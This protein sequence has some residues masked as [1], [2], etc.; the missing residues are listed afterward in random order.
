MKKKITSR[1]RT[2]TCIWVS[3]KRSSFRNLNS[4]HRHCI[5]SLSWVLKPETKTW[6]VWPSK[7]SIWTGSFTRITLRSFWIFCRIRRMKRCWRKSLLRSLLPLCGSIIRLLSSSKYSSLTWYTY[8]CSPFSQEQLLDHTVKC[9]MTMEKTK[10]SKM[11]AFGGSQ[12]MHGHLPLVLSFSWAT[13]SHLKLD[14]WWSAL[15]T[16]MILGI[17][18]ISLQFV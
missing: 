1:K 14:K 16:L 11:R 8:V 4:D 13:S 7:L 12:Y 2:L 18:L 5:K 3:K 17:V 9:L 6:S 10:S 15:N